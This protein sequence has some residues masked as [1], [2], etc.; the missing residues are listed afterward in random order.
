MK[1]SVSVCSDHFPAQKWWV[2][3]GGWGGCVR[4]QLED[5]GREK[6]PT[7]CMLDLG[8]RV[9]CLRTDLLFS[10]SFERIQP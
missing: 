3:A 6:Q 1:I 5:T 4:G 10:S 7:Y 9:G 2:E 8:I